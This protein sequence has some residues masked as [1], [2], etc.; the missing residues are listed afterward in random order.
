MHNFLNIDTQGPTAAGAPHQEHS[1][2][3]PNLLECLGHQAIMA[4]FCCLQI[5]HES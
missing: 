2:L 5:N 4:R 1:R 3:F